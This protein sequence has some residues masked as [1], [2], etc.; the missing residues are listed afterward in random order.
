MIILVTISTIVSGVAISATGHYQSLLIGGG[1]IATVGSGLLY[2]L[3]THSGAG[4][5]IGYQIVA[6]L[7]YGLGFQ[8]PMIVVQGSVEPA[9]ISSATGMLLCKFSI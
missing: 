2:T 4:K 1:V 9:D 3:N 5:W 7:G 8:V 6:G